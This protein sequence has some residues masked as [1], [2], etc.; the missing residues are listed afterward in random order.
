MDLK[1]LLVN[2]K[3]VWVDY[4]DLDGF[5]VEVANISRNELNAMRVRCTTEKFDR[6]RKAKTEHF[7]EEKF[8]SEFCKAS[9]KNWK[10]LTLDKLE[11]LLLIDIGDRDPNEEVEYSQENA[12]TLVRE[13]VAF[14]S[15]LNDVVFDLENFRTGK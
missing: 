14:D 10:G 13:S 12:E 4:P 2:S 15:W 6:Y 7:N 1:N 9:I 5:S 8:S 11:T 3:A